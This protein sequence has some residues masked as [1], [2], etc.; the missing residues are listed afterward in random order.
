MPV[1]SIIAQI[2]FG[3]T[4]RAAPA[5]LRNAFAVELLGPEQFVPLALA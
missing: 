4:R 3:C 5:R 2:R 1:S